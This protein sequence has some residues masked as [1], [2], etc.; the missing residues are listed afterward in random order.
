M[1][2]LIITSFLALSLASTAFSQAQLNGRSIG[3]AGSGVMTM[4]GA[5]AVGW[6]PANLGIKANPIT[7]LTFASF[8]MSVGNN[9]F[10]PQYITDNFQKGDTLFDDQKEDIV[11]QM[12]A[13]QL[14]L[15][16]FFDVPAFGLS[17]NRYALN[18]D[19]YALATVSI[20]S[21]IFELGLTGPV[22]GVPYDLSTL[23][24]SSLAYGMAAISAAQPLSPV[25]YTKEFSVGASFKYIRGLAYAELAEKTGSIQITNEVIHAD[26]KLLFLK[27]TIG[28]GVA[29]DLAA[30]GQLEFRDI[31]VGLT[32]G[33][34]LGSINWE[35][36]EASEL[37]F[38]LNDGLNADSV[39]S[40]GYWENLLSKRDTTYDYKTVST[41][42][43]K[44]LLM[45]GDMPYMNG[46]GDLFASYYQGLNEVPGQNTTPRISVG[47]E[48]R[49]IPVLT[50]RTGLALGGV[51]GSEFSAGFGFR[52][53]GYRL[54]FGA[55]WQRGIL[56]GAKGF[57]FGLSNNFGPH[58]KR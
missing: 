14:R 28:D 8:S 56:A 17:I 3:F 52:V 29:L 22:V 16:G 21:A 57:S 43:P 48:F 34:L 27:S 39:A 4:Y 2:K 55:S 12:D 37:Q 49:W 33:N 41:S 51:E 31:Y 26:G 30:A 54:D 45:A 18:V 40:S 36:V 15:H 24:E 11:S 38:Y 32:L 7:S 9:A 46:K 13:D 58:F 47:T 35:E 5:Q 25:P 42:L 6:N 20:P 19:A 10:S 23:E 1:K 50:L 44:Y 53:W